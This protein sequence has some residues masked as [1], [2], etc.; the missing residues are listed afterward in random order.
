MRE[1]INMIQK[2]FE[3]DKNQDMFLYHGTSEDPDVIRRTG[4]QVD[5]SSSHAA[6]FLTDNP[7]LAIEYAESDQERT[8]YDNITIV[9]VN[10][11]DLDISLLVGDLDHTLIDDWQE[12][13]RETDQC[14]YRG[15]IPPNI[16]TV[17]EY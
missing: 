7:E 9:S 4:L 3:Y 8:G 5:K 2:L 17:E 14:M 6:V 1:Y 10:V 12:S 11:K 16:L 13:L 15:D